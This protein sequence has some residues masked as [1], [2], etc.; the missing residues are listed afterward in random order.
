MVLGFSGLLLGFFK[1]PIKT[2]Q[3]V[4][5]ATVLAERAHASASTTLFTL[6]CVSRVSIFG[7]NVG[8]T[9]MILFT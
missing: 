7:H 8:E 6:A 1:V 3:T 4:L 5:K 2:G 9:E